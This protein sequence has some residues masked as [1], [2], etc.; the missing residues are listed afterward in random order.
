MIGGFNRDWL[1]GGVDNDNL[2]GD[3]GDDYLDGGF[4]NDLLVGGT[5]EDIFFFNN[6]TQA[7]DRAL[8]SGNDIIADFFKFGGTH[9]GDQVQLED[10]SEFGS[11]SVANVGNDSV[12]SFIDTDFGVMATVRVLGVTNMVIGDDYIIVS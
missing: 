1:D 11:W 9:V 5:G 3:S 8:Y 10:S 7:G 4:G 6:N 12:F 2:Y